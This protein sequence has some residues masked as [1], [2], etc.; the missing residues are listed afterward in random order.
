MEVSKERMKTVEIV[1]GHEH[2]GVKVGSPVAR[3][4]AKLNVKNGFAYR[5]M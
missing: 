5:L 2:I 4:D 1:N 3:T